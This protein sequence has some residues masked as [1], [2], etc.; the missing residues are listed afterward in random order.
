MKAW[1][2]LLVS[3]GLVAVAFV[4]WAKFYPGADAVLARHGIDW[5]STAST[6]AA[7]Q[8]GVPGQRPG[9]APGRRGSFGGAL[10][11]T[12]K[13]E[14]GVVNDRLTAIGTGQP[15]R[16][17][18][19]RPLVA[20]QI[21]DIPVASGAHVEA[22]DVILRLDSKEQEL[23]VE[24]ARLTLDDAERKV[25]RL[26][27]LFAQRAVSSVDL[28]TAR[29]ELSEARVALRS[30]ELALERRT[31]TA[32]IG[33]SLGILAVNVGDYVTTQTDVATIDDRS[34]ILVDFYV[35]ERF[36]ARMQVGKEVVA[37]AIAR[38][39]D[40]FEGEVIAVDNRVDEASRTLRVQARIP[41]EN[42]LLRAGMSFEVTLR[43]EGET[44][45]SV[46]PLAIQWDSSGSYVWRVGQ[47]GKAERVDVA[48]IQRNADRVLVKADLAEGDVIVTEG[49]QSVRPGGTVRI[50]GSA[51]GEG[52][53]EK[54]PA[55]APQRGAGS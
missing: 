46:D 40:R 6:D 33:G 17:V 22:G 28:D 47:G 20:G 51:P 34:Q 36:A 26:E 55:G 10:V 32:P 8:S 11:V 1:K 39:G 23:D 25:A 18:S 21:V 24:R 13:A 4:G 7:S 14:I 16:T 53:D 31:V 12:E 49:V 35:P 2:Q 9:G 41:N 42:D 43:F 29:S 48:I 19:I 54:R 30:A 38:P 45:P 5:F 15:V 27:S 44:F 50:V 37:T 3:A 52:G